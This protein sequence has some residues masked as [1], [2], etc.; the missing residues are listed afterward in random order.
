VT[1]AAPAPPPL[2]ALPRRFPSRYGVP[3][4]DAVDPAIFKRRYFTHCLACTFC[5]DWCCQFGVDVD[6]YHVDRILDRADALEAYTGI[7]PSRWFTEERD[8][9][10]DVPG[11]ETWRTQVRDGAC[12]FLNRA[13]RG[14]LLHAFCLEQGIDHHELK[15][16]VDCLFPLTFESGVLGPA[17]EVEAGELVCLDSGPT[18]YR[19]V[20]DELAHFFGAGLVAALDAIEAELAPSAGRPGTR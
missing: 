16:I 10:P 7:P 13:G 11:G 20:R 5:H 15:S 19:G 17:L 1:A 18:L 8:V 12:V 4:L 2:R 14:C 6:R 3:V 9:D